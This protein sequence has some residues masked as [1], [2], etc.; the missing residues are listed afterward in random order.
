[1]CQSAPRIC[2]EPGDQKPVVSLPLDRIKTDHGAVQRD[3]TSH[4]HEDNTKANCLEST[5]ET[6]QEGTCEFIDTRSAYI[7]ELSDE[8][9]FKGFGTIYFILQVCS[10]NNWVA[11][12]LTQWMRSVLLA[13]WNGKPSVTSG[14][15]SQRPITWALMFVLM[16]V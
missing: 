3:G 11:A 15:P 4:P 12:W 1:M 9:C 8:R 10:V 16:L 2:S 13:L 6:P 5:Q 14:F 7:G